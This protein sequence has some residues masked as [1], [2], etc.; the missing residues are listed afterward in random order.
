MP[1]PQVSIVVPT[2]NE[3]ENLPELARRIDAAMGS[4]GYEIVIVDDASGDDTPHRCDELS[5]R[6]PLRLIVRDAPRN[7]LGGAVLEG[8]DR[9]RGSVLVVMDA[10]LQH[11][12]EKIPE[13]LSALDAGADFALGSRY[14][15]G[16]STSQTWGLARRINS[17][18][19]TWLAR[20][21]SG[22]VHDPMSG[23]FALRRD[24]LLRADRLMPLG[25][26]IGLELMCK[27]RARA[28]VEVPIH[29]ARR[30]H[31]RSK[32]SLREQ[33][34]YLEHLSRLYDFCYPRL[35]PVTKFLVVTLLGWAV[36]L[37]VASPLSRGGWTAAA[38]LA[39]AYAAVIAVTALFHHRYIRAQREFLL[40]SRPWL[41]FALVAASEWACCVAAAVWV[42]RRVDDPGFAEQWLLPLAAATVARYVL[43][44]EL[45]HDIRG[46][47]RERRMEE[48]A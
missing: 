27:C 35:S 14:M 32:L 29:F 40:T 1:D 2:L 31:G 10:D 24:T 19:A 12:P 38:S 37:V 26:K 7:G 25:Y 44:K 47:R 13:L 11:P 34:R 30:E 6:Y 18:L 41:E 22:R 39:A 15:A 46:L 36:G 43:R 45:M 28:V 17:T 23:F 9:A 16:G 8:L 20:P 48:L 21:F 33:F 3:A 42:S 4:R 5:Q